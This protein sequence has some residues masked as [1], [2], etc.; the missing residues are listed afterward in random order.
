ME[1]DTAH[2]KIASF[3]DRKFGGE[4]IEHPFWH[5]EPFDIPK[6]PDWVMETARKDGIDL[7]NEELTN[8]TGHSPCPFQ[9]GYL[10]STAR[11]RTLLAGSKNGKT[12]PTFVELGIMVSGEKP[13]SMRFDKGVKTNVKRI[14]SKDNI[15]RFGRFDSKSGTFIDNDVN[16][17]KSTDYEEWDCGCIEGAGVYPDEKI[18]A[19]GEVCW[20]GTTQKALQELW[21]PRL[22]DFSKSILPVD[23]V[24]TKKGN[25]GAS[26]LERIVH[27]IRN[28]HIAII[29]Y[30]AG[31][32][33]F[34]AADMVKS[35]VFDEESPDEDC[36]T[37]AINHCT[38]F[39]R[40]MTPY[41]GMT[42]TRKKIFDSKI[43]RKNN[44]VFHCTSYDSPYLSPETIKLRRSTM[45][46]YEIGARIWGLHTAIKGR[47]YFDRMKIESWIRSYK[48]K[49]VL[50]KFVPSEDYDGIL[51]RRDRDKPGLMSVDI[52]PI[53]GFSEENQQDV[54]RIYEERKESVAYYVMADSAEGSDIPSEAAD[55]LASLV[56]RPPIGE[57]RFPQIVASLRSTLKTQNFAR[58]VSYAI[59]YYNNALLCAEGP[60][61]GS[62]NA[63]FYAEL[64]DYPFWFNQTSL[65]DSTK[66]VRS[67]KG[68]DTNAATRGAIFNGIT[69]V[70]N[71]F[72]EKTKP[73][74]ADEPL[75]VELASCVITV[76][77]GKSRPDHTE[78]STLD[79]AICFGQG[80]YVYS[81]Y[82][83]QIKCRVTPKPHKE[84]FAERIMGKLELNQKQP[85]FLGDS[86]AK[87]R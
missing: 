42:Y 62:F 37:A 14:I 72:D 60:T 63:L 30:E 38:Y 39:S 19:P 25:E 64:A 50:K 51:S 66:K 57:E 83:K 13:I 27:C 77:N 4:V 26:K 23:F 35:C 74:I 41:N 22:T 49:Y 69:D 59:R 44:A 1:K 3:L 7:D 48:T 34:E 55:V 6:R 86:V 17:P 16:A 54:W 78:Q 68:F 45:K 15:L 61:R 80:I 36:E 82:A 52:V 67:V 20:V 58:V 32:R 73:E 29:S 65:R 5:F 31:Y 84:G 46:P 75:L 24:N 10:L 11:I 56:M 81:H 8:F 18:L 9:T 21:W 2:T 76:K 43:E 85:V 28:T 47:P 12:Y 79:S 33:K 87:L 40:V 71:E 53:T 70:I